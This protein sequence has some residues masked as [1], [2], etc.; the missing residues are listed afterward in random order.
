[1]ERE[2]VRRSVRPFQ[3]VDER[4]NSPVN[5]PAVRERPQPNIG[6]EGR[7]EAPEVSRR[8][9][10]GRTRPRFSDSRSQE[11]SHAC[12]WIR[13]SNCRASPEPWLARFRQLGPAQRRG[14]APAERVFGPSALISKRGCR[15]YADRKGALPGRRCRQF[16][17]PFIH[18]PGFRGRQ[19]RQAFRHN[20]CIAFANRRGDRPPPLAPRVRVGGEVLECQPPQRCERVLADGYAAS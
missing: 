4:G 13:Y 16:A 9:S 2:P 8:P 19:R 7:S 10:G 1:M 15:K 18:H 17:H 12:R 20:A 5:L 6:G 3:F 14:S 11:D